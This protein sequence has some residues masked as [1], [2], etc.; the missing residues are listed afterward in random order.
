[1]PGTAESAFQSQLGVR[2][3]G[4]NVSPL[5]SRHKTT[6]KLVSDSTVLQVSNALQSNL[7]LEDVIRTFA[8]ELH[9]VV[10]QTSVVYRNRTEKYH[11]EIGNGQRYRASYELNL[12]D[13]NLGE[14]T[15]TRSRPFL[16]ND[17]VVTENFLCALI[18]PLRNA[19]LYESALRF[20]LRDPLTGINNRACM[21][22][23]LHQQV[24]L[25]HR[26]QTPLSF[27]MYDI[28]FFKSVNDTY[29]HLTGDAV[30]TKV[31]K[32][33]VQCARDS[34]VV[35]RYGGEEF[36][37]ILAN[38]GASGAE[39]LAER[40]R[41][42]VQD[43]EWSSIASKLSVTVSAGIAELRRDDMPADLLRRA[44]EMLYHAKDRGRNQVST[45][46]C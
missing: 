39:L 37:V 27:V 9:R 8:E 15:F 12:A 42:F 28:D 40:V 34:D 24:S 14:I 46:Y 3:V 1:M 16:E 5:T 25:A 38:T 20:A 10:H 31:A 18:Y 26:H 2:A 30:L 44:D 22:S 19:L 33:I 23:F 43:L 41:D 35:F 32:G 7:H 11:V 13:K 4:D 45:A 17:L 36:A 6:Q 21:D 29:G